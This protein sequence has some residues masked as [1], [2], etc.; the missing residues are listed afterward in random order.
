MKSTGDELA[1]SLPPEGK[2]LWRVISEAAAALPA[3]VAN[4]LPADGAEQHDHYI[5]GIPRRPQR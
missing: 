3:D 2:L 1:A 5:Y 4:Q